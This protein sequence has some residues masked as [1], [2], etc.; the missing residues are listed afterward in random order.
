MR[1]FRRSASSAKGP[2][3]SARRECDRPYD[4]AA[5]CLI[6]LVPFI[7]FVQHEAYGL[8]R[9]ESLLCMGLILG[10]GLLLGL[11]VILG[12]APARILIMA[13]LFTF[14]LDM[15]VAALGIRPA[16]AVLA[17]FVLL[18]WLL[19]RH[20]S[21]IATVAAGAVL[22][23]T[24]VMGSGHRT[25][26]EQTPLDEPHGQ[27][28]LPLVLHIILDEHVGIEGIPEEFD[29]DGH[30]AAGLR[31]LLL[32]NGFEVYGRAYSRYF[33]TAESLSN[34]L[35]FDAS[36]ERLRHFG[37]S[38]RGGMVLP[39]NA[40]FDLLKQQGYTLHVVQSDYMRYLDP[41]LSADALKPHRLT[42][43]RLE[44]ITSV[45]EAPFETWEKARF[46][47]SI[48]LR[49]CDTWDWMQSRYAKVRGRLV[50]RGIE[51][52]FWRETHTRT[53]PL[54]TLR[55]MQSWRENLLTAGPGQAH[56]VHFML[57]HYPYAY[58]ADGRLRT[59][60]GD[61]RYCTDRTKSPLF[62]DRE[63]RAASYIQY[64]EQMQMTWTELERAFAILKAAGQWDDAIVIVHGDHG[65][66]ITEHRPA[67]ASRRELSEADL[68]AGFSTLFAVKRPGVGARYDQRLLPLDH[69]FKRI[70]RDG[71][72]PGD[73]L[74]EGQPS[75]LLED[76][77]QP[78]AP[79]PLPPF[80]RHLPP[81]VP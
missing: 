34:L 81:Q 41:A 18:S 3:L 74:L 14:V 50:R 23:T 2:G 68:V 73:Q 49:L 20:V 47:L 28:S 15:Q 4:L 29:P 80:S 8:L 72:D 60:G 59:R 38:F 45:R 33:L 31:D 27:S 54:A 9:N 77:R 63:S 12:R 76:S 16:L 79:L 56:F 61:W 7:V 42:D 48:Y 6:L 70:L 30:I 57:P 64:L 25:P 55:V 26:H 32:A 11:L 53:S 75:I 24:I 52:P 62:N 65:S 46:I 21:R 37:N 43:Y 13:L 78:L 17:G 58:R 10:A 1:S 69:L 35:N 44:T 22:L 51:L 39:R 5:P 40:W 36:R 66:R 71:Q 67:A 19:R